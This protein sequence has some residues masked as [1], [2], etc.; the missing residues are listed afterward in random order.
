[1]DE[2]LKNQ[3]KDKG[4]W[5]RALFMVLFGVIMVIA[6][7]VVFVI[8][9]VQ[10]LC[11]LFAGEVNGELRNLGDRIGAYLHQIVAFQTFHREERPYPFAPFPAAAAHHPPAR[12][13]QDS[14]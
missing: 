13:V 2:K 10:F 3:L 8:A 9:F 12:S 5:T 6:Q 14:R 1:M 11:R 4:L 7:W